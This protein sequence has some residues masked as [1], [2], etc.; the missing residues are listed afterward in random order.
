MYKMSLK[1]ARFQ[2]ALPGTPGWWIFVIN[3]FYYSLL[4]FFHVTFL[5]RVRGE[6]LKQQTFLGQQTWTVWWWGTGLGVQGTAFAGCFASIYRVGVGVNAPLAA[7]GPIEVA[8]K[9]QSWSQANLAMQERSSSCIPLSRVC[10]CGAEVLLSLAD[11]DAA[12]QELLLGCLQL[13]V[14][15]RDPGFTPRATGFAPSAIGFEAQAWGAK[16]IPSK[17]KSWGGPGR[18]EQKE[19]GLVGTVHPQ[20]STAPWSRGRRV[21][22]DRAGGRNEGWGSPVSAHQPHWGHG[23]WH[24]SGTAPSPSQG[25]CVAGMEERNGKSKVVFQTAALGFGAFFSSFFFFS[26]SLFSFFF[27]LSFFFFCWFFFVLKPQTF[28][29]HTVGI[30]ITIESITFCIVLNEQTE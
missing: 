15:G 1:I 14:S 5:S 13:P 23:H 8:G 4:L 18:A 2:A 7:P 27:L 11:T 28:Q 9:R 25:H 12:H 30:R 17:H 6:L 26:F 19:G 3:Y 24:S 29:H 21:P 16:P 10:P 20:P 22:R